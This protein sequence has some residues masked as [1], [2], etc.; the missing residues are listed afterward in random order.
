MALLV[1]F[2]TAGGS[3]FVDPDFVAAVEDTGAVVQLYFDGAT[4]TITD[5]YSDVVAA[6]NDGKTHTARTTNLNAQGRAYGQPLR[7]A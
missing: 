7:P 6:L 2:N 4:L 1:E 3:V 5:A